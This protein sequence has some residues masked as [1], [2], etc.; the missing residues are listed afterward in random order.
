[1][2]AVHRLCF[3]PTVPL[4]LGRAATALH[5]EEERNVA[6][7]SEIFVDTNSKVFGLKQT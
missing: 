2:V 7:L 1:M 4:V 6:N 3:C 5:R